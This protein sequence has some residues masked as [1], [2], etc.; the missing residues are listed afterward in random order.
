MTIKNQNI[1]AI[2]IMAKVEN[3][4]SQRSSNGYTKTKPPKARKK[5]AMSEDVPLVNKLTIAQTATAMAQPTTP[6]NLFAAI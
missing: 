5:L 6:T 3:Q 2:A 4:E 1:A